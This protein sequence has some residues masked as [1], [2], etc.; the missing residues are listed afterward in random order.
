MAQKIESDY[1]KVK[2]CSQCGRSW[3]LGLCFCQETD[4][5]RASPD[6]ECPKCGGPVKGADKFCKWCRANLESMGREDYHF[7]VRRKGEAPE[8]FVWCPNCGE[9]VAKEAGVCRKCMAS[10]NEARLKCKGFS[11][12][13]GA[14]IDRPS[15]PS[16]Q[17]TYSEQPIRQAFCTVCGSAL[18]DGAQYCGTCGTKIPEPPIAPELPAITEPP[19]MQPPTERTL[20]GGGSTQNRAQNLPTLGIV[21]RVMAVVTTVLMFLPWLG[22]KEV[23]QLSSYASAYG[24]STSSGQ[25]GMLDMDQAANFLNNW[26]GDRGFGIMH[27]VFLVFWVVTLVLLAVCFIRSFLGNRRANVLAPAGVAAAVLASMWIVAVLTVNSSYSNSLQVPA[28]VFGVLVCGA[29]T[30]VLSVTKGK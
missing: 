16:D 11:E 15:V 3:D 20:P 1:T 14:G 2:Y 9:L 4:E 6:I 17:T 22:I 8:G 7:L 27:V 12:A 5:I 19:V 10:L 29:F 18:L 24:V 23:R 21:A 25:Y 28:T 30:T 13:C 26:F